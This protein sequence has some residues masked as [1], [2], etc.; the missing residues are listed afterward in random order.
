M[1]LRARPGV[2]V[3]SSSSFGTHAKAE[4]TIIIII[5]II[6]NMHAHVQIKK[7]DKPVEA[8]ALDGP[9]TDASK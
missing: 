1:L 4:K 2:V 5:I 7:P 8:R 6:K 3:A 9:P